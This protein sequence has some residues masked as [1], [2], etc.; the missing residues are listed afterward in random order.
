MQRLKHNLVDNAIQL[1]ICS[2]TRV[3]TCLPAFRLIICVPEYHY[4]ISLDFK[5]LLRE[6]HLAEDNIDF[7][8]ERE[9]CSSMV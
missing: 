9:L 2:V 1:Q 6:H 7:H 3:V 5:K 4:V 8:L